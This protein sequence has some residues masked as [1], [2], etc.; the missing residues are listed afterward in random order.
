[1]SKTGFFINT[2]NYLPCNDCVA[3]LKDKTTMLCAKA[4]YYHTPRVILKPSHRG[5]I[6]VTLV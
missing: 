5:I 1:M 2:N 6:G 3:A 4:Y